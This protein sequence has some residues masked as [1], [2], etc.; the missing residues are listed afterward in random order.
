MPA[1]TIIRET[2]QLVDDAIATSSRSRGTAD[3][4]E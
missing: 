4:I 2:L 3:H 1:P